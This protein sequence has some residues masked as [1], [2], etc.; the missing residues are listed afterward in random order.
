[1]PQLLSTV[2]RVMPSQAQ[3]LSHDELFFSS[4]SFIPPPEIS[5]PS[6]IAL[7]VPPALCCRRRA[8]VLTILPAA[9]SPTAASPAFANLPTPE[10]TA[11]IANSFPTSSLKVVAILPESSKAIDRPELHVATAFGWRFP[12]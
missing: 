10:A 1:L 5:L 6:A 2:L 4:N 9:L 7:V 12:T 11:P 8:S 3:F